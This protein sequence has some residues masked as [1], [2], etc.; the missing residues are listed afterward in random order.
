MTVLGSETYVLL[1]VELTDLVDR[2]DPRKPNLFVGV[3]SLPK[4]GD[5]LTFFRR[6]SKRYGPFAVRMLQNEQELPRFET[7]DEAKTQR[8]ELAQSL[9]NDGYTVN[10]VLRNPRHV[11]VLELDGHKLNSDAETVL[12]VGETYLE[13]EDRIA[14]HLRGY[15]DSPKVR[16]AFLRHRRDL[17]PD[18]VLHSVWDSKAEEKAWAEKLRADGYRVISS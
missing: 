10:P 13:T 3:R 16:K 8:D 17:E 1:T 6:R 9:A 4:S 7:R 15:K 18:V 12:Y 14:N 11:Y 5:L 2:R